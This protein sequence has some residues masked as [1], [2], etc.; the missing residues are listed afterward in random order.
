MYL[1]P[2]I[3]KF[4][5]NIILSISKKKLRRLR[6]NFLKVRKKPEN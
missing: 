2:I 5:F 4:S 1:I 6:L 3:H